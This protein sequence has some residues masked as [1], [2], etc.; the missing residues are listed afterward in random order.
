MMENV[1]CDSVHHQI[2]SVVPVMYYDILKN[3]HCPIWINRYLH[4]NKSH[5]ERELPFYKRKEYLL[6]TTWHLYFVPDKVFLNDSMK[7]RYFMTL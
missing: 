6:L 5:N 3:D 4:L 2:L 7:L 1:S